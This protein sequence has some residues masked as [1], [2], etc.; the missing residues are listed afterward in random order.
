MFVFMQRAATFD[1]QSQHI[2]CFARRLRE[3]LP[4]KQQPV[5]NQTNDSSQLM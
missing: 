1:A 5:I 3:N 2:V 4:N